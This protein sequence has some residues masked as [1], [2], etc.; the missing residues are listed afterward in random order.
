MTKRWPDAGVKPL[1]G[2]HRVVDAL[3][4]QHR[5]NESPASSAKATTPA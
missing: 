4:M 3:G 1:I 5:T 2:Q